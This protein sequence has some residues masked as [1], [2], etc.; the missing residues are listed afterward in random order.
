MHSTGAVFWV[1]PNYPGTSD[2]RDGTNPTNPLTSVGAALALC[3]AERGDV[4]AV[5]Q[6]NDWITSNDDDGYLTPIAESVTVTVPGVRIVGVGAS[7][8]VGVCWEPPTAD[9]TCITIH[10][11]N[12][13]VEGFAFIGNGGGTGVLVQ[14]DDGNDQYGDSAVIRHNFFNDDLDEGIILDFSYNTHI[15]DNWFDELDEY[16]IFNSGAAGDAAYTI[17]HDNWFYNIAT[18]AIWMADAFR[19]H[20]YRNSIYELSAAQEAGAPTNA[21]INLGGGSRNQ[22]HHNTLS[23]ILPAAAAWDY[24]ACNTAGGN[25][26]WMQNYCLNGP[27]TTNPT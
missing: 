18:G 15:H 19:N 13:L 5:M 20:I 8:P 27:S 4:I 17:I 14:W 11:T 26:A 24:D 16:G 12:V 3:Q 2:L 6:N 23:C 1:D 25:D 7:S 22:V 21:M 10:A 9:G